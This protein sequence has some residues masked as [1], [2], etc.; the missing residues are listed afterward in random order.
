MQ[1]AIR[2]TYGNNQPSDKLSDIS[3]ASNSD[4]RIEK[5]NISRQTDVLTQA[6][7]SYFTEAFPELGL[8]A[9]AE[10]VYQKNGRTDHGKLGM[11]VD[12]K[13]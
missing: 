11:I 10:Q 3:T 6:E 2:K 12:R 9:D 8:K 13:G 5:N 4:F 7:Q 1:S